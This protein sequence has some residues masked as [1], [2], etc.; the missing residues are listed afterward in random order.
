MSVSGEKRV[1][2]LCLLLVVATLV[3]YDP[4]VRNQFVDFDNRAYILSNYHVQ[5]GLNWET[6]K[7]SFTTFYQGNWH[8]LTWLSHALDCQLFHLNPI[9]HH[10]TSLLLHTANAVLLFLLLL[11]ATG[12]TWPSLVVG[13]LFALHPINVESVAWAAERKNVLSTLFFLLALHAY[14]RYARGGKRP[15]YWLVTLC[16]ALGLMAKPQIVT[17]PFVLLLWDYWPLQ[18]MGGRFAT[19]GLGAGIVPDQ[20]AVCTPRS[21][22]FLVWEKFPLFILA[23]A[24]SIVTIIAQRA[25]DTVR[26]LS[27]VPLAMRFENVLVSYVR[28]M[29]KAFWPSILVPMYPRPEN[30]LPGWQVLG[31]GTLLLLLSALCIRWR[32]HPYLLVGWLWFLGTLVPMIGMVTVGDQAMA[33]RYAYVA[34]IGL[35]VAVVWTF[36]EAATRSGVGGV[37]LAAPAVVAFFFLG[38]RTHRQLG[39]WHDNEALWR[40]TLSVTDRNYVAHNNLALALRQQGRADEAIVEFRSGK[41]LHKYPNPQ[42]LSL[43]LY[44][45]QVGHPREA[46]EECE[47]ILND[48]ADSADPGAAAGPMIQGAALSEMGQAYLQLGRYDRAA[49]SFQNAR[50]LNPDDAMALM[51]SGILALRQGQSLTAVD[52]FMHAVRIAPDDINVLLLAQALRRAGRAA[53]ADS[54]FAQVQKVSSDPS[55]AQNAAAQLLSLVGLKPL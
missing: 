53:E 36:R 43:A 18:R 16:F 30:L 4:I 7:W 17:L 15:F 22:S 13:A 14:D 19:G 31:A 39:Y 45:L 44:E 3:F 2:I 25:G 10:Y 29:G 21:F 23:A 34:F 54:A 55:Q 46:I 24:D 40:Y 8:P 5:H 51:G 47:S 33:D 6:V 35:F 49:E 1:V 28:Y 37:G 32:S 50:R 11:R 42:V 38:C 27:Q 26:T 41:A 52:Q 48:A 12:L 9:G 20:A